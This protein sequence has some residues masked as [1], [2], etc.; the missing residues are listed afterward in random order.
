M[1]LLVQYLRRW[2]EMRGDAP[3]RALLRTM[4]VFSGLL[5]RNLCMNMNRLVI[6][7]F[8]IFKCLCSGLDEVRNAASKRLDVWLQ[9][10]KVSST[11]F[12]KFVLGLFRN[13]TFA[14]E[15]V[16]L[17][18]RSNDKL[19]IFYWLSVSIFAMR[20]N[21]TPKHSR[22]FWRWEVWSRNRWETEREE[23]GEISF[24]IS[25]SGEHCLPICKSWS[26][27]WL[28]LCCV[29]LICLTV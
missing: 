7:C 13:R 4:A 16:T 2:W 1:T 22:I 26:E 21:K 6:L 10:P 29:Q 15:N 25:Y 19:L 3:S 28:V 23:T 18:F 11:H 12:N 24:E 17:L 14:C 9:N 20:A 27:K 8:C 5:M